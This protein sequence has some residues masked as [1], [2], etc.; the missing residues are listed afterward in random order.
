MVG[1]VA[2]P[3]RVAAEDRLA[4]IAADHDGLYDRQP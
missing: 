2:D 3:E 4:G 1:Q